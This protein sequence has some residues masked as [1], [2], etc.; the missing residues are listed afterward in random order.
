MDFS[1][2]LQRIRYQGSLEPVS[3]TLQALHEAHLLTVPF[4]NLAIHLG[5]PIILQEEALY[6]K[7]VRQRRGGFCYELNG[8]FAWLLRSLGF[9]VSLLSAE[10]AGEGGCFGPAFDHLALCVHHLGGFE[11]LVD[12]GFGDSFCRPLRLASGFE[13]REEHGHV[14]RLVGPAE[15]HSGITP[16]YWVMQRLDVGGWEAQYR[17][18][19]EPYTLPDFSARCRYHQ[20]SPQSHFTQKRIC[21]LATPQGRVTLS[22]WQLITTTRGERNEQTLTDRQQYAV[23]LAEHFGIALSVLPA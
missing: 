2:Y 1:T 3:E 23:A 10:V 18:T 13:H 22:D 21:S 8:L 4:E 6:E 15:E 20:T 16:G 12:V 14:Y 19:L 5:Q 9:E 7:I 17:F 11:W